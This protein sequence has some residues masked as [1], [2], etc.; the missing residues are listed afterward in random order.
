MGL[1]DKFKKKPESLPEDRGL[2]EPTAK[3]EMPKVKKP[4][5][6]KTDTVPKPRKKKATPKAENPDKIAATERGEPWVSI[7]NV[8]LDP[9]LPTTA[10]DIPAPPPPT[11]AVYVVPAVKVVVPVKYPPAPPPPPGAGARPLSSQGDQ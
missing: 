7:V 2:P 9:E 3:P 8:E 5:K 6:P 4:R 11:T 1:F 10:D